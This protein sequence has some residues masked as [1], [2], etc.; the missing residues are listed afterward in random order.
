M[1][2]FCFVVY[3]SPQVFQTFLNRIYCCI[4]PHI[5]TT[6][7]SLLR[8]HKISETTVQRTVSTEIFLMYLHQDSTRPID[9]NGP[10]IS[11]S[12]TKMS[13]GNSGILSDI[14]I[15]WTDF[16]FSRLFFGQVVNNAL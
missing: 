12:Q 1:F 14:I 10:Y 7:I 13:E 2:T 11:T 8:E 15:K 6:W 16:L 9:P 3:N 4:Y 5:L